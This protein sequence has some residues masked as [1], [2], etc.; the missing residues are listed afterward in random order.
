M[1]DLLNGF[2]REDLIRYKESDYQI[3]WSGHDFRIIDTTVKMTVAIDFD[4]FG[5]ALAYL[6]CDVCVI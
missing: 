5:D 1:E 6:I 4:S 3:I 2:T